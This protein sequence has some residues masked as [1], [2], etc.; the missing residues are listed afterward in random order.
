MKIL[1]R[2][3]ALFF[4]IVAYT[5]VEGQTV[6]YI[7]VDRVVKYLQTGPNSVALS[8]WDTPYVFEVGMEPADG[9]TGAHVSNGSTLDVDLV[10]DDGELLY[11]FET[12]VESEFLAQ[13]GS[14]G[15]Y[16]ITGTGSSVG[17]FSIPISV[18]VFNPIPVLKV[19]NYTELKQADLS[20]P[21]TI[22]WEA[23]T[24]GGQIEVEISSWDDQTKNSVQ[25]F[26]D[27]FVDPSATS[28]TIP[29]G[30][31]QGNAYNLYDVWIRFYRYDSAG[32]SATFPGAQ[33][34]DATSHELAVQIEGASAAQTWGGYVIVN[35]QGDVDTGDWMGWINVL[36]T[37]WNYSYSLAGWFYMQES[38]V[39]AS[40]GWVYVQK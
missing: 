23:M 7:F 8:S 11:E 16:T 10:E 9:I 24:G 3:R 6:D 40:G 18:G 22:R 30:T 4:V 13:A 32:N 31:L 38:A 5:S 14:S 25:L 28:I 35:G 29:G 1:C 37:P 39:T 34:I 26:E 15:T 20:Q 19:T 12:Q 33:V 36:K 17:A 21:I 2:I 27:E